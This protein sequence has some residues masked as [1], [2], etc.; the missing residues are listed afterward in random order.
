MPQHILFSATYNDDVLNR[1]KQYVGDTAMF[2][3]KNESLKLKGVKQFRIM[4]SKEEKLDFVTRLHTE[5]DQAM[6]M[7]F[8]NEKKTAENL[9]V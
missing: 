9:I 4:L 7:V 5:L 8:V 3:L 1:I 2:P 6:T